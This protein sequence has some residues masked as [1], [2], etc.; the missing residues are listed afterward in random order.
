MDKSFDW[1]P[2]AGEMANRIRSFDWSASSIGPVESWSPALRTILRI[3]LS[4]PFPMLLWWGRDY[5]QF[6]N[7]AYIPIPG[8]KHPNISFGQKGSDCWAEIWHI[9]RPMVDTPFNGGPATWNDDI[10]LE[11]N[12]HNFL[13]E[14]HFVIAYSPV[15]DDSVPGGI[16]G[17]LATVIEITDKVIGERRVV[18]LRDV[19]A[20]T[21]GAQNAEEA[22]ER[23][24]EVLRAHE[25]DLP[26]TLLY[27]IDKDGKEA[28]LAGSAGV[29]KGSALA[30][31]AISLTATDPPWPIARACEQRSTQVMENLSS[32]FGTEIPT[33]PW[34]VPP[35]TALII[36]VASRT[37]HT[38]SAV[39]IAGISPRLAINDKVI[40]FLELLAN[41]VSS[42][43][44]SARAYDEERRRAE[45]LAELDRAKT[46]FFSNVSHEFR[47]P[48]TLMQ[49]PIQD[50][51]A[52]AHG[53]LPIGATEALG[54]AHRNSLRLLKLVN[55][56][57]D[58]SRIEAGRIQATYEATDLAQ[59]TA[60][61]ASSFRSVIEK[62]GMQL[63]VSCPDLRDHV[64]VDR[65]MFEK[66]LLNLLSNAFKFTREGQVQVA[67]RES[68][69]VVHLTVSDTGIGIPAH[70][71]PHIFDRFHRVESSFAR[72]QEGSGIG[73]ALVQ[74]LAK[75]HGGTVGV[76]SEPGKGS[77]F[78]V[79]FPKGKAHLPQDRI[80][81][82]SS[83]TST[84]LTAEHFVEEAS[85]WIRGASHPSPAKE[86]APQSLRFGGSAN[87]TERKP[88]VVWADDNADMRDYVQS[89][90]ADIADVE[91]V[92]DG[93]AALAAL[94]R[95]PADLV[96]TDVMMPRLDGF[97]L[98]QA[99]RADELLKTTPVILLSARAG[100]E[101]RVEGLQAGADDYLTKPFSRRELV[102]CIESHLKISRIRRDSTEKLA[103]Q[104]RRKDEFIATLAHELRNPLAPMSNAL[105]L[106]LLN[107]DPEVMEKARSIISRQ[108][109]HLVHLVDDLMDVNRINRGLIELNH[110]PV[111]LHL[112]VLNAVE[113]TRP[114]IEQ[115]GHKLSVRV[116]DDLWVAGDETRLVQIFGNL[117]NNAAKYTEPG[118]DIRISCN[119]H[120]DSVEISVVDNGV[121][122][123]PDKLENVF[124]MFAQLEPSRARRQGGL[125]IGLSIV[126]KLVAL[127]DGRIEAH[128]DGK[129][130]GARF[131]VTLPLA[132]RGAFADVEPA[133]LGNSESFRV[134]VVDDNVDSATSLAMLLRSRGHDV[135]ASSNAQDAI[136]QVGA[137]QPQIVFMDIGMPEMNGYEA[138]RRIRSESGGSDPVIVALTGW[139]QEEDR[140][141]AREAGFD[142]HLVKP[143]SDDALSHVL[144]RSLQAERH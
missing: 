9:L 50:L 134:L 26:F 83:H 58:F 111:A 142:M 103:H 62:A 28:R 129:G 139:G 119:A 2:P 135:R 94:R 67:L 79:T 66:I 80:G 1:L 101:S 104:D 42:A 127:H 23:A 27:L 70:Q 71:L 78:I 53:E 54:I 120:G 46:A 88:R 125:G 8:A 73:L 144:Q 18:A 126:K 29:E 60:D 55:T 133:V 3:M 56:L 6:Y 86:P 102:A 87:G 89:L 51:L 36:P 38:P 81:T 7:D 137:F 90:L 34:T 92:S 76:Q 107:S 112:A 136:E 63:R 100:E 57:L 114:V 24:A 52:N 5:V 68:D 115:F 138:C 106:L 49:G 105:Q 13:E 72:T 69:N 25:R 77:T 19:G 110:V 30:P 74:E 118:G 17:V 128:S 91:A 59:M 10:A 121:G 31:E 85:R 48:L 124:D 47:T 64:Y 84:A 12:R 117:L 97:G 99:V 141:Q 33:G 96:L 40:G 20:K 143:L 95:E 75:L 41:Q 21:G 32:N 82:P 35:H 131:T 15:P 37:S 11:M 44:E 98:L 14:V 4:N 113:A 122:I 16:G 109:D 65:D 93:E 39:M 132:Q 45:S 43:I 123:A 61:V 116:E 108:L 22:C 140:R 130:K